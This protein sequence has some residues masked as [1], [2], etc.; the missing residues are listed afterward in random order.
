[1]NFRLPAELKQTIEEA[2]T[3]AGQTVSDFAISVLAVNSRQVV[4]EHD[5]TLLS[6]RDRERFMALL[7]QTDAK[8]NKTLSAAARRYKKKVG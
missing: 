3:L 4:K 6:N 8:P 7:D 1:M 5:Q 2:A